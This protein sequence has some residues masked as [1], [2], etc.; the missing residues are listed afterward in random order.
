LKHTDSY[1]YIISGAGCAGLSLAMHMIHSGKFSN[2]KILL[3]DQEEKK[4]NDRTWCFWQNGPNIFDPI[5]FRQWQELL[6]HGDGISS[7]LNIEPYRYKMIRG[8]DF[9]EYC[10][11]EIGKQENFTV[12]HRN[13]DE[14]FSNASSTGVIANGEAI[15]CQYVFNSVLFEKPHLSRKEFWMLQHFKGWSIETNEDVFDT[16]SAT[17]MDFRVPQRDSIAFC[18]V[19]PSSP[20][21]ALIEYTLFSPELLKAEEYEASLNAYISEVLKISSFAIKDQEFGAI[22]MTNH[23]FVSCYNNIIH[24]GTAGGQTK[25]STGFTF[26]FIQKH[27]AALVKHLIEA[28]NPFLEKDSRRFNFYDSVLLD[29]LDKKRASGEKIFSALFQNNASQ[30][31]LKFLDNETSFAEELKIISTLP[32]IP[33]LK[34]AIST[35]I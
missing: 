28:G 33:F 1:D 35:L 26:S 12:L 22:P 6:F 20:R 19:L 8:I 10:F 5:V 16:S 30:Q 18:Y 13:V 3:I 32:T 11:E 15:T 31:V 34:S 24:I 4:K 17:L 27:S 14:I 25:A 2:K 7:S 29:V 9:Y 23:K 21:K